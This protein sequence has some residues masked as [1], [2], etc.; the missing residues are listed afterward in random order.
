MKLQPIGDMQ[1]ICNQFSENNVLNMFN[2][3]NVLITIP[4]HISFALHDI[5]IT[6]H[7]YKLQVK[8]EELGRT[9]KM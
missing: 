9:Y 3:I 1:Y 5:Y 2:K 6:F 7:I 4:S 8:D